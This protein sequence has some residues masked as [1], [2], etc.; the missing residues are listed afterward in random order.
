MADNNA[1]AINS[2]AAVSHS[3]TQQYLSRTP[4]GVLKFILGHQAPY[5]PVSFCSTAH[6]SRG[7]MVCTRDG[8]GLSLG[9]RE[10]G[11]GKSFMAGL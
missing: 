9:E 5:P 7:H 6:L 8:V 11:R 10:E 1:L 3:L 4:S 2:K